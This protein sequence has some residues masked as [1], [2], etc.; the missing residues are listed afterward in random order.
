MSDKGEN[1]YMAKLAEQAERYDEV[2][3]LQ[4]PIQAP[5]RTYTCLPAAPRWSNT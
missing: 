4:Q 2:R 3:S 1:V 5:Y